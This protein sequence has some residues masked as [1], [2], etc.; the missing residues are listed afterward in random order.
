MI[1]NN[2]ADRFSLINRRNIKYYNY[3]QTL[4]S[5]ALRVNLIPM[6]TVDDLQMQIMGRMEELMREYTHGESASMK[7]DEA[8]GLLSS[9]FFTLD[10]YL[11]GY[12]DP[13]YAISAVQANSVNE[14]FQGGQQQ[15][16]TLICETISFYVQVKKSRIQ[17]DNTAYNK[18]ID[19]EVREFL[20]K[21]DYRY[22]AQS[23]VRPMEY[24]LAFETSS[25]SRGIYYIKN[26]LKKLNLENCFLNY[27]EAEEQALLF[28][29]YAK[30]EGTTT[31]DMRVNLFSVVMNNA[32]GA[33]ILGKYTGILTLTEEEIHILEEKLYRKTS[34]EL[35]DMTQKAM[36]T[37]LTDLP[38]SSPE[39]A[40]YLRKY[41][42]VFLSLLIHARN[43]GH[44][45]DLFLASDPQ[46]LF[47]E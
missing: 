40:G 21:Y 12:H 31:T 25:S 6:E 27:F 28:E 16:K 8:K 38:I 5:E 13:M 29:T 44:A 36:E 26:Y 23:I 37:M 7:E 39:P 18:T 2:D 35:S 32:F 42:K 3:T 10:A 46:E 1:F 24:P 14:M 22:A 4:I 20:E 41:G 15:I 47:K 19:E 30:K 34:R 11:F 9:V 17:T 43:I 33:A 45:D